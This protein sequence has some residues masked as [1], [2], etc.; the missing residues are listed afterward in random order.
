LFEGTAIKPPN[1]Y[2][3]LV[4]EK[5]VGGGELMG[6]QALLARGT[7]AIDIGGGAVAQATAIGK[8]QIQKVVKNAFPNRHESFTFYGKIPL[9]GYYR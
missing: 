4:G 3:Y 1:Q 7:Q 8:K 2:R 6:L 5:L 9:S